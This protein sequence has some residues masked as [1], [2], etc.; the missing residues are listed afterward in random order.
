MLRITTLFV[1]ICLAARSAMAVDV[2]A[3]WDFSNPDLSEKRFRSALGVTSGSEHS[4]AH[5]RS[6]HPDPIAPRSCGI[7]WQDSRSA[8][9]SLCPAP[10]RCVA[11]R[12]QS[13]RV[14][15]L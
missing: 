6:T 14:T 12:P 3:M 1:I 5:K 13:P 4:D 9:P 8:R 15:P 2:V 7:C 11:R 10:S